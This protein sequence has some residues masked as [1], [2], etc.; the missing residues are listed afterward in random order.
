MLQRIYEMPLRHNALRNGNRRSPG[1][2]GETGVGPGLELAEGPRG[3]AP[4]PHACALGP[5]G[6]CHGGCIVGAAK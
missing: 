2:A 1:V 3:V 6:T 4:G 5:T